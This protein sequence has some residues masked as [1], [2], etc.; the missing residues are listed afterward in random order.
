[1]ALMGVA[2]CSSSSTG[3]K[4]DDGLKQDLAATAPSALEMAPT[5]ATSQMVVSPEE[6]GPQAAPTPAAH[7]V[8][9]KPTQKPAPRV[10]SNDNVPVE[11]AVPAP[12]MTRPAPSAPAPQADPAPQPNRE[13]APLPPAPSTSQGRQ[14][15]VYK[16]EGQIFQQ[17]PWIR[18]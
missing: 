1:M 3:K 15:G 10:A 7:K 17:M 14:K 18:P 8:I 4:M 12:Q 6:E 16:T 2:A 5:S 9:P 11:A 13:P